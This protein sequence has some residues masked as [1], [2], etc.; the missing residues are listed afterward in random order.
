MCFHRRWACPRIS[1]GSIPAARA[2][3]SRSGP[4]GPNAPS[5]DATS[6]GADRARLRAPG[7]PAAM[8]SRSMASMARG[9]AFTRDVSPEGT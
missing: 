4:S 3:S 7:P 1:A 9:V 2:I 5:V 6:G 8:S